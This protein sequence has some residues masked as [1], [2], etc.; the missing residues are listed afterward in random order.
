M[1]NSFT[2][3]LIFVFYFIPYYISAQNYRN[4]FPIPN[5]IYY[6][7]WQQVKPQQQLDLEAVLVEQLCQNKACFSRILRTRVHP[8]PFYYQ[9]MLY[10]FVIE[11]NTRDLKL[12]NLIKVHQTYRILEGKS[13]VLHYFNEN[14]GL[15]NSESSANMAYAKLFVNS[16]NTKDGRFKII[17]NKR[18]FDRFLMDSKTL[19][20]LKAE[21]LEPKVIAQTDSS[22]IIQANM[23]Y[24]SAGFK[25]N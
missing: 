16:L 13:D 1:N 9:G 12:V 4:V 6:D 20:I 11:T 23:V 5:S 24:S 17:E 21:F 18:A 15:Y 8:L 10:E 22:F 3:V 25:A 7:G 2:I 14:F 19:T